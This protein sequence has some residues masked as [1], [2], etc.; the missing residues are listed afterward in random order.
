LEALRELK[1]GKWSYG[2]AMT[3]SS[4]SRNLLTSLSTSLGYPASWGDPA[5]LPS[6]SGNHATTTWRR[7]GVQGRD[8]VGGLPCELVHGGIGGRS[9]TENTL[10]RATTAFAKAMAIYIPVHFLA[11]VM[12][13]ESSRN[14][15]Y[16][17][18]LSAVRSA[19]FLTTFLSTFWFTVCFTRT[20]VLARLMTGISHQ[21]WDGPYGCILAGCLT[22]GLSVFIEDNK[23]RGEM[24][25]YVLSKAL[26]T[27]IPN[28][29][30]K[31][32][33]MSE[34]YVLECP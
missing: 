12:K 13:T 22:S 18:L 9:C 21:F 1:E 30:T 11:F 29:I 8:G 16:N 19:S 2:Y 24:A 10:S 26:Q 7:L 17:T 33:V 5:Q 15:F 4:S 6:K 23:R 3:T 31:L 27:I 20:I 28:R 34:R 25:L 32:R 14:D